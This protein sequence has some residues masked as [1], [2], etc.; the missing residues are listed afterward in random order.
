MLGVERLLL[1]CGCL[2]AGIWVKDQIDSSAFQAS[3]S[4]RFEAALCESRLRQALAPES[5]TSE[6]ARVQRKV[7]AL[8]RLEIRRLGISVMIAEGSSPEVLKRAVGHLERTAM[9]G[10]NG[11]CA[12]AG[13]RDTFLRGL[14]GVRTN[15]IIRIT[16]LEGSATYVV[17]GCAVVSPERS[18]LLRA[19][20]WPSL[21]LVT[22]YPFDAL[23]PARSRF[24]VRARLVGD[25]PAT[26]REGRS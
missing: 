2:L 4:K 25:S 8:G 10:R 11:N 19:T 1:V 14:R 26:G 21:T 16:T 15:D 23:G 6:P 22:C 18:D 5:G 13:H 7:P 24:V 12:L 9:P 20:R 17:Q 3:E